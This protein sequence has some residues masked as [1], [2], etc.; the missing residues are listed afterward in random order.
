MYVHDLHKFCKP[1]LNDSSENTNKF[2]AKT[3]ILTF[4]ILLFYTLR[5]NDKYKIYEG[6]YSNFRSFI[7]NSRFRYVVT[8]NL[9]A[10][11][12]FYIGTGVSLLSRERFL[13]I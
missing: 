4:A 6:T 8:I 10:P 2:Q 7:R 9:W 13:Y 5:G 3:N 11:R 12:F 1:G